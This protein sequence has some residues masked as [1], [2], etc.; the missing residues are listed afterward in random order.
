VV[1]LIKIILFFKRAI[2]TE[3]MAILLDSK[4]G[5]SVVGKCNSSDECILLAKKLKPDI[6][7]LGMSTMK[8]EGLITIRA[9]LKERPYIRFIV[10]TQSMHEDDLFFAI[11]AGAKAYISQDVELV[12]LIYGIRTVCNGGLLISAPMADI[13]LS[14]FELLR[15]K[16]GLVS[17]GNDLR[18]SIREEEVLRLIAMGRNN[19]EI[20]ALLQISSNTIKVHI[21]HILEKLCIHNRSQAVIIAIQKGI[22]S[23]DDLGAPWLRS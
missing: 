7:I 4:E 10:Y 2:F 14:N 20:A 21:K 3:A 6:I 22:I 19:R 1:N 23:F 16:R 8:R 9:I 17:K 18:L 15:H 13:F 5:L 12:H 11:E